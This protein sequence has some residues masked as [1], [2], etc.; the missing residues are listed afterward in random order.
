MSNFKPTTVFSNLHNKWSLTDTLWAGTDAM[1]DAGTQ[2][3]PREPAEAVANYNARLNRSVLLPAY[4]KTIKTAV[5]KAFSRPMNIELDNSVA[6]LTDNVDGSGTSLER[7]AKELTQ[8]AINF[9]VSYI[10]VDYPVLDPNATLADERAAGALPY[11]VNIK[12]TS[13]LEISASYLEGKLELTY[14]RFLETVEDLDELENNYAV[15]QVKEFTLTEER[16]V[17]YTI[18][19]KDK[20]NKEY[21][22]DSNTITGINLIPIV[23]VY[24][25]KI[26]PFLGSPA[27]Y[28]LAQLNVTHWQMYS[29]YLNIIHSTGVP[30][31]VVKGFT[32]DTDEA[33]NKQE[34]VISPNSAIHL[35][36]PQGDVKWVEISG[37]GIKTMRDAIADLELNMSMNGLELTVQN[38]TGGETATGRLIDA[39]TATSILKSICMDVES[40]LYQ[41]VVYSGLFLGEDATLS[42]VT[43]NSQF[44]VDSQYADIIELYKNGL[45]TQEEASAEIKARGLLKTQQA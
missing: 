24:G 13:V 35:S 39:A 7:F 6:F 16:E 36:D 15:E 26:G 40:A 23:P 18:Y 14:F 12:P 37:Q 8:D 43:I 20:D 25:N 42:T 41:A 30:M 5:G 29:D 9:G 10:L 28:D 11:W 21:I 32:A 34:L 1:R 38:G 2:Y 31:L 3:L 44:L 4:T 22:Y 45:L 33:G 27:L 19:R 17:V